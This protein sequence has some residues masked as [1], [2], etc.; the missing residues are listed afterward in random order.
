MTTTITTPYILEKTIHKCPTTASS[1]IWKMIVKRRL[2][3]VI[4][5]TVATLASATGRERLVF[6]T[7]DSRRRR[8]GRV[9]TVCPPA[10]TPSPCRRHV[11]PTTLD[12]DPS[13]YVPTFLC[14][15]S[16]VRHCRDRSGR[17]ACTSRVRSDAADQGSWRQRGEC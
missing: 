4:I 17:P 12:T 5:T 1:R 10:P 2:C 13:D 6:L 9:S 7:A 15:G 8:V 3:I 14:R 16:P 11:E